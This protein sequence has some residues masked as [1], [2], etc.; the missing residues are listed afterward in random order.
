MRN[1]RKNITLTLFF[2][3]ALIPFCA[4]S[5]NLLEPSKT[6]EIN[7]SRKEAPQN[8]FNLANIVDN[9]L[10]NAKEVETAPIDDRDF[11]RKD[12]INATSKFNQ[13]NAKSAYDE[14]DSLIEK[15]DND[16]YLLSLSKVLYEIG[17]FS[18]AEKSSKKITSDIR[19]KNVME[20]LKTSYSPKAV[21]SVDDEIYFAKQYSDIYFNASAKE[22]IV[23]LIDKKDTF[24]KN[25]FYN[26]T[27][28]RA[29]LE[30]KQY[31][32]AIALINK[33]I[34]QNPHNINYQMFKIDILMGEKKYQDAK[35]LIEKLEK[36]TSLI[37]FCD[38][39]EIKKQTLNAILSKK[40]SDRKFYIANKNFIDGNFEKTKKECLNT[41]NFDKDNDK[42]LSLYAK[43]ELATGKTERAG[44]YFL[45]AYKIDKDNT[46]TLIGLGD[47]RYI[48]GDYKNSIKAYKK[49][50]QKDKTNYEVLI[51]LQT[52]QRQIATN[53]KEL[54]KLEDSI[55]KL[56]N[57]AY[58][59][60]YKSAISIAQKNP[61]LKE[62]FLKRALDKNPM[63]DKATGELIELY[64][65]NKNYKA[66]M[67][68]IYN[69]AFTLEKNYYYYYLCGLYNQ[70]QNKSSDAISFYKTSLNLNPD[71]EVANIKL[72]NLIPD[73]TQ[74]EI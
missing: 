2:L 26:Y 55:D 5:D 46:D 16:L 33:A 29:Y 17:F 62:E 43:A 35:S 32:K 27:L 59:S 18:L 22:T 44:T 19:F 3:S 40:E 50:Y 54:Q 14:Y 70:A 38:D 7:N 72:L 65:K 45:N 11:I 61:V 73:K 37:T 57:S 1:I 49:A 20:D 9:F 60:Y 66:A 15:I 48:H 64:L 74:E 12:F 68:L 13:G 42:L 10:T 71:F 6:I 4:A 52:A 63:Y 21:L 67:G 51:K 53:P 41:L 47:I 28:S 24:L 8:Y 31:N 23:E 69:T 56:P 25:D 39:I 30:T 58:S 36:N 34:A